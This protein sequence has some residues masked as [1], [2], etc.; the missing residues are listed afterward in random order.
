MEDAAP[1]FSELEDGVYVLGS[2]EPLQNGANE[3]TGAR[4][5][6]I[7]LARPARNGGEAPQPRS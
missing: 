6:K 4:F 7:W 3:R 5:K 1:G 2:M